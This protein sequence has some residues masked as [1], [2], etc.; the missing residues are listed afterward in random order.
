MCNYY[1]MK[2]MSRI[3]TNGEVRVTYDPTHAL[4]VCD[5]IIAANKYFEF[6]VSKRSGRFVLFADSVTNPCRLAGLSARLNKGKVMLG[7]SGFQ[8]IRTTSIY[9]NQQSGKYEIIECAARWLVTEGGDEKVVK[10]NMFDF[11]KNM[12]LPCKVDYRVEGEI[13]THYG[14]HGMEKKIYKLRSGIKGVMRP[15]EIC[16]RVDPV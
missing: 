14:P 5:D 11:Y 1:V 10:M 9:R 7:N 12:S 6:C 13:M 8:A 3:A 16:H 15:F 4:M 2:E